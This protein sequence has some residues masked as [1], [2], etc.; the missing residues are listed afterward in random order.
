MAKV[1]VQVNERWNVDDHM[2]IW[3]GASKYVQLRAAS[4]QNNSWTQTRSIFIIN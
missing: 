1:Q 4:N 3:Y 2:C